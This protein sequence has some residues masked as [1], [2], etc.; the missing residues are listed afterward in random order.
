MQDQGRLDLVNVL[1][2]HGRNLPETGPRHHSLRPELLATPRADDQVWLPRDHFIGRHHAIL[3]CALTCP[4]GEDV[5]PT[6][7]PNQL[8]N[9]PNSGNQRVVPLFEEYFRPLG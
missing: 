8:R 2:L 6:G 5:D 4:L 9:P 3:R 1:V 7:D